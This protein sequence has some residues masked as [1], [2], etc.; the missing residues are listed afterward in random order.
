MFSEVFMEYKMITNT[1]Q[2]SITQRFYELLFGRVFARLLIQQ[3]KP[4]L[5]IVIVNLFKA[6]VP[7]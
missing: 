3:C 2:K 5:N 4:N 1:W 6:Y 7:L